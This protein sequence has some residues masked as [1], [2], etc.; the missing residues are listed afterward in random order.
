LITGGTKGI[1][2]A[3]ALE[4]A[5]QGANIALAARHLDAAAEG[6]RT[7]I[8]ALGRKCVLIAADL[9][10]PEDAITCVDRTIQA[11]GTV[12]VMVH[13]AGGA[14]NGG[15]LDI[16]NE[17]W[18]AAFDVHVHAVYHLCRQVI[19]L[20]QQ[21]KQGA[22]ILISSAA[23]IRG[24][25]SNVAYQVVK[26]AL[27]QFARALAF[28]FGDDNIRVNCVAPG[29][30]RTDFHAA[31]TPETKKHNI[32]NRIPLHREGTTDQVASLI[33]ELITN[34]FIT[35]ETVAIDGG[36]TMRVP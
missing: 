4:L 5:K 29:I 1:G 2:A 3:T 20:M 17:M 8:E 10:K 32:D 11:F 27:P 26:G 21:Q 25:K 24:L 30:I 16:T 9:S 7:R 35:G 13:S 31:M 14:V 33:R 12:D 28:E 36:M 34:D 18:Q 19:P 22:I 6:V 23:G 15:L